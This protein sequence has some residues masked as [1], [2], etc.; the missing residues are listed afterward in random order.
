MLNKGLD[1]EEK[2]MWAWLAPSCTRLLVQALVSRHAKPSS[3][4]T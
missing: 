4:R 1:A 3:Y 2:D